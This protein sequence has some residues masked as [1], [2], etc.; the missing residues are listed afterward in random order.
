MQLM[1]MK[2]SVTEEG[3]R[4]A[5]SL[6]RVKIY[7]FIIRIISFVVNLA[8]ILRLYIIWAERPGFIGATLGFFGY[9]QGELCFMASQNSFILTA[10]SC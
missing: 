1:P 5:A 7:I 4:A 6:A 8:F 2:I 9:F 10:F 3:I